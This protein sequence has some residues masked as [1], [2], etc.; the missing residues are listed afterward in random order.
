MTLKTKTTLALAAFGLLGFASAAMADSDEFFPPVNHALAKQE[1]SAC[2]MAFSASFLPKRSWRKI[3]KTLD[4]HFGEDASLDAKDA[5][6]IRKWLEANAADTGG[7]RNWILRGVPANAT[8]MRITEMPW[9]QRQHNKWEVSARSFKKAGSKA[10]CVAC[11][12]GADRGYFE[13]D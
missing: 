11:H 2:H 10:N 7:G 8:P 3:M 6:D 4:N 5:K 1:C 13:D 9:W 12:R